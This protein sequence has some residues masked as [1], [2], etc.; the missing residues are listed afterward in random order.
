V[1][2]LMLAKMKTFLRVL[3][4]LCCFLLG[5]TLVGGQPSPT[6]IPAARDV[7][8]KRPILPVQASRDD[9]DEDEDEDEAAARQRR[10][11]PPARTAGGRAEDID[12]ATRDASAISTVPPRHPDRTARARQQQDDDGEEQDDKATKLA[13]GEVPGIPPVPARNLQI[14]DDRN[15]DGEGEDSADDDDRPQRTAQ[16]DE[17]EDGGETETGGDP[18]ANDAGGPPPLPEKSPPVSRRRPRLASEPLGPPPPPQTWTPAEITTARAVCSRLITEEKFEFRNLDP[19]REGACGAPAPISFAGLK[20]EVERERIKQVVTPPNEQQKNEKDADIKS[21]TQSEKPKEAKEVKQVKEVK[22]VVKEE[23]E[24]DFLPAVTV[25]CPLASAVERW[26]REVVLPK[27]K[28]HLQDEIVALVNGA[29]Y[30]CRTRYN[31][32]GQR[33]SYHAFAEAIDISGFRTAKG[34]VV[35]VEQ[36]WEGAEGRSR[37][38]QD[39]H[40]GACHIFGT[41]LG[42]RA[43]AAHRNHFHF[44]MAKRRFS[45]YCQ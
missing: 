1:Q 22:E 39:V 44:D 6:R 18:A 31:D 40:A 13:A 4:A 45:S 26:F 8:A 32:P 23:L 33:I 21:Q 41:V 20:I 43:N 14:D 9:D 16:P 25:T 19:I 24:I 37:F 7:P 2:F 27:A 11:A 42:P 30:N 15:E 29:A 28:E 3:A 34:E 10:R 38:L 5:M 36:H 12:M 17:R 35:S